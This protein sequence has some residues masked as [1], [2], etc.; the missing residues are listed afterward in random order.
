MQR[1]CL[2]Q[3]LRLQ[4]LEPGPRAEP[5]LV[6]GSAYAVVDVERVGLTAAAIQREHQQ[7]GNALPRGF[8]GQD[9]LEFVRDLGVA[10]ELEFCVGPR[11][12]KFKPLLFEHADLLL[13]EILEADVGKRRPAP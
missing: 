6:E 13:R 7:L 4:L 11:L 9:R 8:I 5:D 1:R 10:A 2:L 12:E 3:D